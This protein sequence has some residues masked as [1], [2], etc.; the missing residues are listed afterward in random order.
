MGVLPWFLPC[1]FAMVIAMI[2]AVAFAEVFVMVV[3][4]S[5]AWCFHGFNG[6]SCAFSRFD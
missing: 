1:V 4:R 2:F 6:F 3:S 5:L